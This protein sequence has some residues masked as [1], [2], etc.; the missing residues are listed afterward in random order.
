MRTLAFIVLLASTVHADYIATDW[1]LGPSA[2]PTGQEFCIHMDLPVE[3]T[4]SASQVTTETGVVDW[5]FNAG[6][7]IENQRIT[8]EGPSFSFVYDVAT[9]GQGNED[10]RWSA[11]GHF[12]LMTLGWL[13]TSDTVT[14]FT[15]MNANGQ[16]LYG[17]ATGWLRLNRSPYQ[18]DGPD[19]PPRF[20]ESMEASLQ[21][22]FQAT[23]GDVRRIHSSGSVSSPAAVPEPSAFVMLGVVGLVA[24]GMRWRHRRSSPHRIMTSA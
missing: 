24:A 20:F 4:D 12:Y 1:Q 17:P 14:Y 16:A 13:D 21:F 15:P 5:C 3:T 10:H 7:G 8:I 23:S 18:E 9:H 22:D 2:P 11:D 19:R 6:D